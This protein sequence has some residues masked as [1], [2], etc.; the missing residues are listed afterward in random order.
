MHPQDYCDSAREAALNMFDWRGPLG[1]SEW[2]NGGGKEAHG[3]HPRQESVEGI[4]REPH[5]LA[6]EQLE[7]EMMA[8]SREWYA[9]VWGL[10]LLSKV[11]THI[12]I[13]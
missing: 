5:A 13:A 8:F 4:K 7:A 1:K 2:P 9:A 10:T 6:P 3:S 12:P 11:I